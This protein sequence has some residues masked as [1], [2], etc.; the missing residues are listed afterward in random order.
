MFISRVRGLHYNSG[1]P[2]IPIHLATGPSSYCHV[3]GM[4]CIILALPRVDS[5]D[6]K[7]NGV[8]QVER[9]H[10]AAEDL[11]LSTSVLDMTRGLCR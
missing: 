1:A 4:V 11:Y 2:L 3:E 5:A 10:P 9:V 6:S 7:L 8:A